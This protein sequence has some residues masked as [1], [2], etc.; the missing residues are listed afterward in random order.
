MRWDLGPSE[1]S[2]YDMVS[3]S[4]RSQVENSPLWGAF[5][6]RYK[7]IDERYQVQSGGHHLFQATEPPKW[8]NK[9]F[10]ALVEKSFRM[11][12]VQNKAFP[13]EPPEGWVS[14]DEWLNK[15]SDIVRARMVVR[16]LDGP[17]YL[18]S[19]LQEIAVEHGHR[20]KLEFKCQEDG[21]Y[22]AHINIRYELEI[23]RRDHDTRILEC[24]CELQVTTQLQELVQ[25]LMHRC[26]ESRRL[27]TRESE[28]QVPWQWR[29]H[30]TEFSA[31]YLGH[32]LHYVEGMIM[33]VRRKTGEQP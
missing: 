17:E 28:E 5:R 14:P 8:E 15:V 3:T 4:M 11:N 27:F 16:Y 1:Q 25:T 9:S 13:E 2:Y 30:E 32:V 18:A 23:P 10:D 6:Q 21:Y 19:A 20:T 7:D 31:S 12:K 24:W 22:A 33:D 26:Y 29:F